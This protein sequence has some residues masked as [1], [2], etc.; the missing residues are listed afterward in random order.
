MGTADDTAMDCAKRQPAS[1]RPLPGALLVAA[2]MVASAMALL[3]G[4]LLQPRVVLAQSNLLESV[5]RDPARAKRLCRELRQLNQ[6]GISYT[7]QQALRQI[8]SQEN[9]SLM[10][11]EVLTTYVVGLHCPDVR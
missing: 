10:D 1:N 4:A 5:R 8:A 7:S 9:L 6:Q 2:A 3:P 11:A